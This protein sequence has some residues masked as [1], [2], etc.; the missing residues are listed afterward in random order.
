MSPKTTT[1]KAKASKKAR[2]FPLNKSEI[3]ILEH[4]SGAYHLLI[5]AIMQ[6]KRLKWEIVHR[7]LDEE[8][9]Y[10]T[11]RAEADAEFERK[12]PQYAART[13]KI[14]AELDAAQAKIRAREQYLMDLVR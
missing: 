13:K 4:E 7:V 3:E 11:P 6:N 9:S 14:K 8:K 12:Y 5:E 1:P 10:L 2:P